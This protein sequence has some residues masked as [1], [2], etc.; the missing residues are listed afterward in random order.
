[1]TVAPD[2]SRDLAD[3]YLADLALTQ[4]P[5]SVEA[6]TEIVR[7]HIAQYSFASIGPRLGNELPIEPDALLDRIVVRRRGGYCFEQ[8]GLLFAVLEQLG[9]PVRLQMARVLVSEIGRAHV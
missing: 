5:P 8:N 1:M 4:Q 9:Y 2:P 6:L 3:A 7:R